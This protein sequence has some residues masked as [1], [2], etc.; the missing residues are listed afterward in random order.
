MLSDSE[1]VME[2]AI[3]HIHHSIRLHHPPQHPH[4]PHMARRQRPMHNSQ[5]IHK[6]IPL[7]HHFNE[8]PLPHPFRP[9]PRQTHPTLFPHPRRQLLL[10]HIT[11]L[12]IDVFDILLVFNEHVADGVVCVADA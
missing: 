3:L 11:S 5:P 9:S 7:S 6:P 2:R 8:N 4:Y 10:V 1:M 12:T